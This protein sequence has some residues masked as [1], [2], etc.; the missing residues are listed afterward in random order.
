MKPLQVLAKQKYQVKIFL[1]QC[2]R[3]ANKLN[4]WEKK[5][6]DMPPEKEKESQKGRNRIKE[7]QKGRKRNGPGCLQSQLKTQK[8]KE[9][10]KFQKNEK[11][12]F[13]LFPVYATG[14]TVRPCCWPFLSCLENAR[15]QPLTY[16][17]PS[18]P[19][20]VGHVWEP[21]SSSNGSSDFGVSFPS[22]EEEEEGK[23]SITFLARWLL[24]AFGGKIGGKSPQ[25][26]DAGKKP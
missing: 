17:P 4:N 5:L 10:C 2:H 3:I 9:L 22:E 7:S 11:F 23:D 20:K 16:F 15:A 24:S 19:Q 6:Y 12:S 25:A 26:P 1:S 13:F 14:R 8:R 18:S 21:R